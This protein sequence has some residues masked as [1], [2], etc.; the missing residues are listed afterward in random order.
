[1]FAGTHATGGVCRRRMPT[2]RR[3]TSAL[4]LLAA[5]TVSAVADADVESL[6]DGAA[7][8]QAGNPASAVAPSASAGQPSSTPQDDDELPPLVFDRVAARPLTVA[9]LPPANVLQGGRAPAPQVRAVFGRD[10][11]AGREIYRPIVEREAAAWGVPAALLDSVMAVESGYNPGAVGM[12]GEIGLMQVMP[13]T[14]R[15]LGFSGTV[16]DL[17][18]PEVNIHYG[19]KYLAGAWRKASEDICTAAM[20]YRAGHG[21]T[22]FSVLSVEYCIRVRSHLAAR[23]VAVH[24]QVPT[25]TFGAAMAGRGSLRRPLSGGSVN[26]AELNT[27]L[28]GLAARPAPVR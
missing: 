26:F 28:R 20:K 17:A 27:L 23:G 2:F 14:A 22:R 25:P 15:M 19:A 6:P 5:L 8:E 21:E 3:L 13:A 10:W 1:M 12:D 11:Q 9:D 24:G 16:A 7:D 18:V 4:G